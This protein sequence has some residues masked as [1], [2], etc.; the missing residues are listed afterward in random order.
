MLA[1]EMPVSVVVTVQLPVAAVPGFWLVPWGK[2]VKVLAVRVGVAPLG[3]P[4]PSAASS[5]SLEPRIQAPTAMVSEL[6]PLRLLH[7]TKVAVPEVAPG[8]T[9]MKVGRYA[10]ILKAVPKPGL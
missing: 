8:A 7:S 5:A 2:A 4:R 9:S 1:P 3:V 6:G 10:F